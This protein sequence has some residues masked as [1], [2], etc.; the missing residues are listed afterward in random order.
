MFAEQSGFL[1]ALL[2]I[3][4]S[5]V[6]YV[7]LCP[8]FIKLLTKLSWRETLKTD[9][10]DLHAHKAGTYTS[11]GVLIVSVV[12]ITSTIFGYEHSSI[13]VGLVI[14]V[15]LFSIVGLID[16]ALKICKGYGL[17]KS[18]KMGLLVLASVITMLIVPMY[19]VNTLF[20][21][22]F[23]L[24]ILVGTSN[25]VNLT[26]GVDG[27]ATSICIIVLI[28]F[29]MSMLGV[30]NSHWFDHLAKSELSSLIVITA[31][32]LGS[33]LGFLIFNRHPAILFMGD[34]GSLALGGFIAMLSLM[35]SSPFILALIGIVFVIE[36]LSVI[37]QVSIFKYKGRRVFLRAPIHHHFEK[38][39][40][41][42]NKIV[43]CFSVISACAG[44]L[45]L[46]I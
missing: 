29:L 14:S 20:S 4:I 27:L 3:L 39:G 10:A 16:D 33:C 15:V 12:S 41:A 7:V 17:I 2:I 37:I 13:I 1:L 31:C 8:L 42:E 46:L 19:Q 11:G 45:A 30:S 38:R 35:S 18:T 43:V 22:L 44:L 6:I 9:N 21:A 28:I 34:T 40:W 25:S 32:V 23:A 36:A 24:F 5:F 26:D